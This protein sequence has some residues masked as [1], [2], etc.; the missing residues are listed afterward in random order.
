M[1]LDITN[2]R[3]VMIISVFDSGSGSDSLEEMRKVECVEERVKNM[4]RRLD[5][6]S[7]YMKSFSNLIF[8][9]S[10]RKDH[11]LAM[12]SEALRNTVEEQP[13]MKVAIGICGT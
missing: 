1:G 2:P 6:D 10:N 11:D 3:R 9:I 4:I 7:I 8:A 12:L 5:A 13:D